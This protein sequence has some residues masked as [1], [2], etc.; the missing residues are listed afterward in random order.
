MHTPDGFSHY[1][2][3]IREGKEKNIPRYGLRI[4]RFLVVE[5]L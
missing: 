5:A 2:L 4:K 1:T 3:I